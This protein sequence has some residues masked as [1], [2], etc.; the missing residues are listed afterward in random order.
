MPRQT[1]VNSLDS[2]RPSDDSGQGERRRMTGSLASVVHDIT[3]L[4][5]LQ[6]RLF[7]AD[8]KAAVRESIVPLILLV[9]SVCMLLG[10]MPVM[11]MGVAGALVEQT[12]LTHTTS[13]FVA[14][15][16]GVG[17]ALAVLA[18]AGWRLRKGVQHLEGS[19]EELKQNVN[20]IK[21]VLKREDPSSRR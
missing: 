12:E 3:E 11:L 20:W 17:V 15:G 6:T 4:L 10:A 16:A 21:Q 5:E 1:K 9:V 19:L 7:A 14:S 8:A 18:V 2:D 13:L